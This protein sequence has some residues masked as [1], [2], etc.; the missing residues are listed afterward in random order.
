MKIL[1]HYQNTIGVGLPESGWPRLVEQQTNTI[2]NSHTWG[3]H[4]ATRDIKDL[5]TI[6]RTGCITCQMDTRESVEIEERIAEIAQGTAYCAQFLDGE[7]VSS[8][9]DGANNPE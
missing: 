4:R 9:L 6:I 8:V 1:S 5:K 3:F 2:I 7:T